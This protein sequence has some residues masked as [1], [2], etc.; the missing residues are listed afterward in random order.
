MY[1]YSYK[2]MIEIS[3]SDVTKNVYLVLLIFRSLSL[4]DIMLF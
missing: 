2:G 1:V 3:K 4:S